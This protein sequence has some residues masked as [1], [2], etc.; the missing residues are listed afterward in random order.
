M[1]FLEE[2]QYSWEVSLDQQI[3]SFM[4]FSFFLETTHNI[5]N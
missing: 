1:P 3:L 2:T 5:L 4:E